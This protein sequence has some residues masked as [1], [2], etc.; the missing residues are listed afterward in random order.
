MP[1]P[2]TGLQSRSSLHADLNLCWQDFLVYLSL[3][4]ERCADLVS[5]LAEI[6]GVERGAETEGD[7]GAELDIVGKRCDAAVVDLGLTGLVSRDF[8]GRE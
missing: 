4:R 5:C 2:R 8:L 7:A 6:L 3:K 1:L